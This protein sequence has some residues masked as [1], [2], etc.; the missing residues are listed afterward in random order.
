[1]VEPGP[2]WAVSGE[3]QRPAIGEMMVPLFIIFQDSFW[4]KVGGDTIIGDVKGRFFEWRSG[5]GVG[6]KDA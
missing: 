5:V 4:E 1:M 3:R 2:T 6:V